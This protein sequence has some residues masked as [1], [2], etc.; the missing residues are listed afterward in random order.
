LEYEAVLQNFAGLLVPRM[1]DWCSIEIVEGN[2]TRQ[3]AVAHVD[4]EKA[5][6]A[7]S[8]RDKFPPDRSQP[9]GVY[10]VIRTGKAEL[11]PEIADESLRASTQNPEQ[12][13]LILSLGL[14]SA[15]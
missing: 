6:W 2:S 13:A 14:R 10:E 8:M 7:W 4:P 9:Q 3:A 11:Y 1:G 5:R 15:M 12:R